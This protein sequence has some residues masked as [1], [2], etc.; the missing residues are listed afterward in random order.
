MA[1]K[2]SIIMGVRN[3]GEKF[4]NAVKSIEA[5][6]YTDWEFVI[7]DDGSADNSVEI[8]K[9]YAKNDKRIILIQNEKNRSFRFNYCVKIVY[10]VFNPCN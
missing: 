4:I 5:Q 9:E 7:C 1:A 8:V 10:S 2:I 3:G 6:T